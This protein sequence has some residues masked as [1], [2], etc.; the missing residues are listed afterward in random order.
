MKAVAGGH[1]SCS[2]NNRGQR[3]IPMQRL[4]GMEGLR[5]ESDSGDKTCTAASN[6]LLRSLFFF[7]LLTVAKKSETGNQRP[8][9]G[10]EGRDCLSCHKREEDGSCISIF[11][12]SGKTRRQET[13]KSSLFCSRF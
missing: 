7:R 5:E 12:P 10:I 9:E 6:S 13:R 2:I 4:M 3:E 1:A 8:G 11:P